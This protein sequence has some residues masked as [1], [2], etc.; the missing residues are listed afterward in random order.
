MSDKY[1]KYDNYTKS[2]AYYEQFLDKNDPRL[3][4]L[5]AREAG[6]SQRA[7]FS[8]SY[9]SSQMPLAI[10]GGR[11]FK[12]DVDLADSVSWAYNRTTQDLDTTIQTPGYII[13]SLLREEIY[14]ERDL[15]YTGCLNDA[16]Y[17]K[18]QCPD[19]KSSE[20]DYYNGAYFINHI[21]ATQDF[22]TT[23]LDYDGTSKII[24]L[25]E[26]FGNPV[27]GTTGGVFSIS[28]INPNINTSSFDLAG[29]AT[30]GSKKDWKMANSIIAKT[31]S[32]DIISAICNESFI[33]L[34]KDET[35]YRLITDEPGDIDGTLQYHIAGKGKVNMKVSYTPADEICT[36]FKL[37]YYYSFG[38]QSYLKEISVS[39]KHSSVA[40]LDD[41]QAI[42]AST[43]TNYRI[44]KKWEY[45]ADWIKDDATAL[46]YLIKIIK[47]HTRQL[48]ITNF[49][50]DFKNH[51]KY[52]IGDRILI[53]MPAIVPDSVDYTKVFQI[54]SKK[55]NINNMVIEFGLIEMAEQPDNIN[56]TTEVPEDLKTEDEDLF[57]IE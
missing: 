6:V 34:V 38:R 18:V 2:V 17:K 3:T 32:D 11:T 50:G 16:G 28:N 46:A 20:D 27:S 30:N 47:R 5:R 54:Y 40:G 31:S 56:L 22:V 55:L 14:T 39:P 19:L 57:F 35:G 36:D 52:I 12:P 37:H 25:A 21:S 53:Y 45:S 9:S 1:N 10:T 13:E 41:Y 4:Y 23:I 24:Y 49:V 15:T 7:N 26:S 44:S 43:E 48:L 8:Q 33:W 29:N 51:L 42:C